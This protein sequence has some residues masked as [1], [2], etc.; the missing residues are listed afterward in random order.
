[1]VL[2][3]TFKDKD[4]PAKLDFLMPMK[5]ILSKFWS[6]ISW[7]YATQLINQ[8]LKSCKMSDFEPDSL[9]PPISPLSYFNEALRCLSTQ[10]YLISRLIDLR[11]LK[12]HGMVIVWLNISGE[13]QEIKLDCY[14]PVI[15]TQK[16]KKFFLCQPTKKREIWPM[17]LQKAFAKAYGGYHRILMGDYGNAIRDLTGAP[18]S[19]YNLASLA[20][21]GLGGPELAKLWLK[22]RRG[23]EKRHL[24]SAKLDLEALKGETRK[25]YCNIKKTL[26]FKEGSQEGNKVIKLLLIDLPSITGPRVAE[27]WREINSTLRRNEKFINSLLDTP[28]KAQTSPGFSEQQSSSQ[29]TSQGPKPPLSVWIDFET[30]IKHHSEVIVC[31]VENSNKYNSINLYPP[32]NNIN[33]CL[34]KVIVEEPSRYNLSINQQ[35]KL[36]FPAQN[37]EYSLTQLIIV[38]LAEDDVNFVASACLKQRNTS[39]TVSLG[40][41]DYIV[42]IEQEIDKKNLKNAEL[43][44]HLYSSFRD[45]T[46]ST[47]G[48]EFCCLI[49]LSQQESAKYYNF[50]L[51]KFQKNLALDFFGGGSADESRHKGR[52]RHQSS[53][54]QPKNEAR[55]RSKGRGISKWKRKA[56]KK[57]RLEII[58]E[59]NI[60]LKYSQNKY[61]IKTYVVNSHGITFYMLR[62]E[63]ELGFRFRLNFEE[64]P[65]EEVIGPKGQIGLSHEYRL[66]PGGLDIFIFRKDK[67]FE[68]LEGSEAL[69]DGVRA[70][71]GSDGGGKGRGDGFD[72]AGVAG[73]AKKARK[74][75]TMRIWISDVSC[76]EKSNLSQYYMSKEYDV[77]RSSANRPLDGSISRNLR[78]NLQNQFSQNRAENESRGHTRDSEMTRD[79]EEANSYTMKQFKGSFSDFSSVQ[80]RVGFGSID[81]ENEQGLRYRDYER[82]QKLVQKAREQFSIAEKE[83]LD[84]N[85]LN[86]GNVPFGSLEMNQRPIKGLQGSRETSAD[87]NYHQNHHNSTRN[88]DDFSSQKQKFSGY[89][90]SQAVQSRQSSINNALYTPLYEYRDGKPEN[91]AEETNNDKIKYLDFGDPHATQSHKN[92]QDYPQYIQETSL[93]GQEEDEQRVLAKKVYK[94]FEQFLS[95]KNQEK[96]NSVEQGGYQDQSDGYVA[97]QKAFRPPRIEYNPSYKID[98]QNE[99][100]SSNSAN[101]RQMRPIGRKGGQSSPQFAYKNRK[102]GSQVQSGETRFLD[103]FEQH[104]EFK[105]HNK[106]SIDNFNPYISENRANHQYFEERSKSSKNRI[107][108]DSRDQ[109]RSVGNQ[110]TLSNVQSAHRQSELLSRTPKNLEKSKKNFLSIAAENYLAATATTKKHLNHQE[111]TPTQARQVLNSSQSQSVNRLK[112]G[113]NQPSRRQRIQSRSSYDSNGSQNLLKNPQNLIRGQKNERIQ[114]EQNHQKM[115]KRGNSTSHSAQRLPIRTYLSPQRA[116]EY[117]LRLKIEEGYY[118]TERQNNVFSGSSDPKQKGKALQGHQM[119]SR[120]S[121]EYGGSGSGGSGMRGRSFERG[122]TRRQNTQ[123][124][125]SYEEGS[126]SRRG[127]GLQDASGAGSGYQ[128]FGSTAKK[129]GLR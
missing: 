109:S 118:S 61:A 129:F 86:S 9:A 93:D 67:N 60:P 62:N 88:E 65:F 13:W 35:D 122:A 22:I 53:I 92:H 85:D 49:A 47:Y 46:L 29:K 69:G 102:N 81:R 45:I 58:G 101:L 95:K 126:A 71:D 21:G 91:D 7:A 52:R 104:G 12:S 1:M 100:N 33:R 107:F 54:G 84:E 83:T 36:S 37:F 38:E 5:P 6:Q 105:G 11:Y 14:F 97:T 28:S 66:Q 72:Q 34:A 31:K 30:F 74:S 41:G 75:K 89:Q 32:R 128:G 113:Q 27:I 63:N 76:L 42:L 114:F 40:K 108:D 80:D 119:Y 111:Y 4:F 55:S 115:P 26:E 64:K 127:L 44:P 51:Y 2:Q 77:A 25:F 90:A 94:N 43:R 73:K 120:A 56:A 96:V 112:N 79:A 20:S 24:V 57:E 19:R 39:V 116:S 78:D 121:F 103:G 3:K 59:L 68:D 48:P 10:P 99:R 110:R 23:I 98:P 117:N 18:V 70:G 82:A 106:V 87:A 50:L 123:N 8:T 17:I 124:N 15:T 125:A 16:I